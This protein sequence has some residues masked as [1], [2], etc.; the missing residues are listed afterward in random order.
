M[1]NDGA[2]GGR[3]PAV[4][5]R[6]PSSTALVLA[7]S[8][9][10]VIWGSTYLAIRFAVETLPPFLMAGVRFSTAGLLLYGWCRFR[11]A[12]APRPREWATTAVVGFFLLLLGNGGLSWAEQRVPSG[13]AALVVATVPIWMVVLAG[14]HPDEERASRTEWAGVLAGLAGVGILAAPGEEILGSGVD[15]VGGAVVLGASFFWAAGSVFNRFARL[16]RSPLLGTSM[17]MLTGGGLLVV[18]GVVLGEAARL[19]PSAVS[20]RSALALLYLIVFG[21]LVA[22]SAYTWLLKAARPSLVG[23]YAYVNPVIAVLLGWLLAGEEVTP[24]ALVAMGVILGSVI[25]IRRARRPGPSGSR[26]P[27][28]AGD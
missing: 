8:A 2:P 10:Y 4:Q 1:A 9:V 12:D 20:A 6:E 3:G 27:A 28:G 13:I 19:D 21:S 7:F 16:P 25:V 5:G 15:L 11:G 26:L 24:R 17:T 23:T 14:L 18:A 22:F